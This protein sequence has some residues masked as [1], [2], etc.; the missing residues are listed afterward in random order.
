MSS[1]DDA[2]EVPW[3]LI[4]EE[5]E[6]RPPPVR[7]VVIACTGSNRLNATTEV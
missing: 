5:P 4:G 1:S 7:A 2:E 3:M 6:V